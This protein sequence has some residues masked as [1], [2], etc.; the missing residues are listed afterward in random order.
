MPFKTDHKRKF[1]DL[2]FY[3]EHKN[4]SEI[5]RKANGG[6]SLLF[7]YLPADEKE[8]LAH[9][10][11]L[12]QDRAVFIDLQELFAQFIEDYGVED[13]KDNYAEFGVKVFKEDEEFSEDETL[14][15]LII[16][17]IHELGQNDKIPVLIHTGSLYG[18]GIDN[19]SIIEH[20]KVM[21]LNNPLVVFY[22]STMEGD[23]LM[24][25][26]VKPSSKYRCHL[27]N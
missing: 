7:S 15:D 20:A 6:N 14:F 5:T 19:V 23:R 12:F 11:D 4:R 1:D 25:L 2:L 13:L 17:K 9:A 10:I 27:I 26:G 3:L 22:P 21:T 24:F 18:T 16:D 8:Y